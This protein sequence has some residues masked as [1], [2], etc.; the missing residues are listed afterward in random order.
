MIGSGGSNISG[1]SKT[2]TAGSNLTVGDD[3]A[4]YTPDC[5]PTYTVGLAITNLG[6]VNFTINKIEIDYDIGGK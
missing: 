1:G 6:E 2:L 3:F 4:W 5:A